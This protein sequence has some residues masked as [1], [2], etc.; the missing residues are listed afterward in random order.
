L[1]SP[2]GYGDDMKH[3]ALL[4]AAVGVTGIAAHAAQ[5]AMCSGLGQLQPVCLTDSVTWNGSAVV[6]DPYG[7]A[8]PV[9]AAT[10]TSSYF[11]G[12]Q[13]NP[14]SGA[15]V[16]QDIPNPPAAGSGGP[17]NFYDSFVFTLSANST[18]QGAAISFN[19]SFTG[20]SNLQGRIFQ[21][22]AGN[23]T[24]NGQYDAVAASNLTNPPGSGNTVLDAW[25]TTQLGAS[26]FYVVTLN[27]QPLPGGEY[28]LQFRGEVNPQTF[29]GSYGGTLSFNAVPIPANA[30]LLA[31]ALGAFALLLRW[32]RSHATT[33]H[34]AS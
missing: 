4:A 29:S 22:N 12:D 10:P 2:D 14:G 3:P 24:T 31:S 34:C 18:V 11:L 7:A 6:T 19:N 20:I 17:W 33:T 26:G 28:V 23:I 25:T 8:T 9:N 15:P 1:A 21:V 27:Q 16:N 5:A 13:F 30:W 32:R